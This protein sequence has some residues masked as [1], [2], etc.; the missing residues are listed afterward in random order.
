[1]H[2]KA[3]SIVNGRATVGVPS[4][5]TIQPGSMPGLAPAKQ[6]AKKRGSG[7]SSGGH[8]RQ[9]SQSNYVRLRLIDR[10]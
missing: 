1:M 6:A 9:N 2:K 8:S 5:L 7:H 10:K 3:I 4:G